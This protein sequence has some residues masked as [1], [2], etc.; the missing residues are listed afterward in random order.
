MPS[1][2]S[3]P[4]D[5]SFL[6]SAQRF[7]IANDSRLLPS[8]V[9]PPRFFAFNTGWRKLTTFALLAIRAEFLPSSSPMA[10]LSRSLSCLRSATIL[11]MSKLRSLLLFLIKCGPFAEWSPHY[12][13]RRNFTSDSRRQS[14]VAASYVT[15][16]KSY[17][18]DLS[19]QE[20]SPTFRAY[21]EASRKLTRAPPQSASDR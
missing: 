2:V 5:F 12:W 14:P 18:G 17:T 13:S 1:S 11:S 7:F 19:H 6:R 10:R 20:A 4:Y 15:S 9:R 8:G 21:G 3:R 16:A